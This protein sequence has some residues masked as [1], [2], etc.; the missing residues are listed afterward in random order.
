M[1]ARSQTKAQLL[2]E[3]A[4]LR[5]QV[6]QLARPAHG[7]DEGNRKFNEIFDEAPVGYHELDAEGRIVRI[8]RT[9]L[10]MLGYASQEVLGRHV[11]ELVGER[12]VSR[13]AVL[14]KLAGM[15]PPDH[16]TERTYRR[17]DGTPISV[18]FEDRLI[19]DLGGRIT[20]IRTAIQDITDRKRAEE[21]IRTSEAQLSNAL[22]M[23]HAGHW[24]YDV[25][26]DTFTFNDNFYRIFRTTAQ[27]VGGYT[28]SA[29]DYARRFCHP[30]DLPVVRREIEASKKTDDPHYSRELEHRILY[31]NGE[32]GYIAVRFFV[33]KDPEGRTVKTCGVNQDITARKHAEERARQAN[34]EL[35]RLVHELEEKSRQNT[36]LSELRGFLV[37]CSSGDEIG[38]MAARAM[39]QLFPESSGA[40]LLLSPS[41]TDLESV[42]RWGSYPEETD[43]NLFAPDACWGLRRG[44]W[45]VIDDVQTGLVCP[46]VKSMGQGGYGCLPLTARGDALGLLH[47]RMASARPAPREQQ[48][49]S[50][51]RELAA[52]VAEILSL[53]IW[54]MRLRE[55]LA[56]QAIK[57]PLTGLF[58]RTFMEDALQREIYRA[59][60]KQAPIGVVMADV[61]HFKKFNDLHGHGA[62][63]LVL[64]ELANFFRWRMRKG[65]IVCRY[66]GEEFVLILP[67]STPE[68][69]MQRAIQFK[70]AVK[71]LRASYGGVELGPV[72]LSM[73]VSGFPVNGESP[74]ELLRAADEALY[75]AKQAGRDRVVTAK[76]PTQE[77][78]APQPDGPAALS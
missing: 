54:N 40:L 3:V 63:D 41:K 7:N 38:P 46:H 60:R 29:A 45:H 58:N 4:A 19:R 44:S 20:G 30:D 69:A 59:G 61:D 42:A 11:W 66:G 9:E 8:N 78:G 37:A 64:M 76:M 14:A 31:S 39:G 26:S 77:A 36:I 35:A 75:T 34:E 56:N 32:V 62:G 48:T 51:V 43:E 74:R 2:A 16:S 24:E 71:G 67:E 13:E 1:P 25:A 57:D 52:T 72:T 23:A 70:D 17:K 50:G 22:R 49:L 27:D 6:A 47:V 21:T 10:D 5:Q 33:V 18:L 53:S 12:E 65:D 73:G 55:T 28:M 68:D 15:E